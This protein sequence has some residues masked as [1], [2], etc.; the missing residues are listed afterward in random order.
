TPY[1]GEARDECPER[2][3]GF[4]PHSMEVSLHTMLLVRTGEVRSEPRAELLPGLN[5]PRS[6][7]HEPSPGWPSQGYMKVAGHDGAV[8][9]SCCDG[10][11]VH[12]QEF[13]RVSGTVVFLRQVRAELRR[14]CHYAEVIRERSTAYP[15]HRGTR[16]YPGIHRRLGCHR[17]QISVEVAT[18]DVETALSH[19]LHGDAGILSRVLAVELRPQV[20]CSCTP[21]GGGA[22]GHRRTALT[23]VVR[24]HRIAGRRSLPSPYR[25]GGGLSQM[26]ETVNVVPPLLQGV[27]RG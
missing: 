20:F 15:S 21:H 26:E 8:T 11:N 6:K 1:L 18:L 27:W 17:V 13:R 22:H 16:L 25:T 3:P 5:S 23:L 7:V 2:L 24:Y 19:P 12:L 9:T 10:G 4:L 14:P